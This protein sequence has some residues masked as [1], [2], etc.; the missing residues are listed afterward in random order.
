MRLR[1][2]RARAGDARG[3]RN[4]DAGDSRRAGFLGPNDVGRRLPG[5]GLARHP[6]EARSGGRSGRG[7]GPL[8]RGRCETAGVTGGRD[9]RPRRRHA[10][11]GAAPVA[12]GIRAASRRL[13]AE[14]GAVRRAGRPRLP[15]PFRCGEGGDCRGQRLQRQ[16]PFNAPGRLIPRRRD[17]AARAAHRGDG[18]GVRAARTGPATSSTSATWGWSPAIRHYASPIPSTRRW[19]RAS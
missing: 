17:G 11:V 12:G 15:Y 2:R 18:T 9:R 7:A 14:R 8:V 5:R 19:C 13:P 1:E 16:G 6:R 10:A 4:G 3:R